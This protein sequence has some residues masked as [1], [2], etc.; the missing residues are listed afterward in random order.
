[1]ID[2]K[3]RPWIRGSFDSDLSIF[4]LNIRR[5]KQC[6]ICIHNPETCGYDESDEDENGMCK[7]W[8]G[9]KN[10]ETD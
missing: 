2:E 1:M 10:D 9:K 5:L 4:T 7:K 6:L 3:C 8:R